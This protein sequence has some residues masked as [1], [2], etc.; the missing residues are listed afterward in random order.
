MA[1]IRGVMSNFPCPKCLIPRGKISE[2]P[3]PCELRTSEN[4][5]R[6]LENARSQRRADE[7]EAVLIQEGLRDVD[8][9]KFKS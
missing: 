1:L 4:V 6:T 3:G 2:F 5:A 9:W 8:V 7:K